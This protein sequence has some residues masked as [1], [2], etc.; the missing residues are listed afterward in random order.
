MRKRTTL[1]HFLKSVNLSNKYEKGDTLPA[2]SKVLTKK[3]TIPLYLF[4]LT[5]F[6][7]FI[8]EVLIMFVPMVLPYYS[9]SIPEWAFLD[10]LL[11]SVLIFPLLYLFLFRPL[12]LHI[13]KRKKAEE[14]LQKVNQ[15]LLNLSAHLQS[16]R[17]EERANIARE[18]H[19]ELGQALTALKMEL[20]WLEKKS[21]GGQKI[22]CNKIEDMLSHIDLT[23]DSV[24]RIY[25][26]LRPA[27]LDILGLTDAIKWQ[28]E[29][30]QAQTG[31]E[32]DLNIRPGNI[33]MDSDHST[34][35]FRIF[36]EALTNVAR[37]AEATRVTID[38]EGTADGVALSVEDNGNGIREEQ[39]INSQSFGLI[40]MKERAYFLG[41]EVKI[42]GVPNKGTKVILSFHHNTSGAYV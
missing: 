34:A 7:V 16:I 8:S 29:E 25:T 30:F 14:E 18:I 27:I 9:F 23:I 41:G 11:L 13:N 1:S 37:H 39:I 26:E 4:I 22:V 28:A 5:I 33:I 35:V 2:H 6:S 36:Q 31:I 17:E 12:V 15:R 21:S 40:G 19:D 3:Y 10:G 32:C 24:Q 42:T 38:I 20:V